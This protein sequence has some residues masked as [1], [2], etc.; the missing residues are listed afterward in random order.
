MDLE[1]VGHL[2][3]EEEMSEIVDAHFTSEGPKRGRK[4]GSKDKTQRVRKSKTTSSQ[5]RENGFA[6]N[7]KIGKSPT[8]NGN[9]SG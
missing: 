6:K 4:K 3:S 1:A 2:S 5:A 8:E 9:S 7:G